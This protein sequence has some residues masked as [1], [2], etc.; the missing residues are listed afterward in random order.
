MVNLLQN[1]N[2]IACIAAELRTRCYK[3]KVLYTIRTSAPNRNMA[4]KLN[5]HYTSTVTIYIQLLY[6][7]IVVT[8]SCSV[9]HAIIYQMWDYPV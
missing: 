5:D 8:E 6:V 3:V 1:L 7:C 9:P 4:A 2:Y